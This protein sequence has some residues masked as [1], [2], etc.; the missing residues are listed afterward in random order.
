MCSKTFTDP[1]TLACLHTFCLAC[2]E[3]QKAFALSTSSNLRCHQCKAPFTRSSIDGVG[4][5]TCNAFIDSLIKSA[6][7]NEGDVNRVVKC[8]FCENEDATVHCVECSEN[9][10]PA[11]SKGHRKGKLS[12]THQ[13]IPLNEAVLLR[14]EKVS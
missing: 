8:D 10:C 12:A 14:L 9:F 1:R 4:T 7:A 3:T 11:C 2:L 5:F 6:K 13:Q